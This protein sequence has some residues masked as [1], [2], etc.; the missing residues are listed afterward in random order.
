MK[1]E[2]IPIWEAFYGVAKHGNFSKASLALRIPVSQLSKR[3]SKLESQL[4]VRLF[5]RSTRAVSLTDEGKALLPRVSAVLEDLSSI[6]SQFEDQKSLSGTVRVTCIPF[7][8]ERLLIPV[9]EDFMRTN[10]DIHVELDLSETILNLI[11]SHIDLAIRIDEPD[12]SELVYRKLAPNDLVFCA[13]PK[14]LE[15]SKA[16]LTKPEHLHK[17]PIL[18]LAVHEKCSF[19]TGGGKLK[20]FSGSKKLTCENGAF[21]TDLAIHG[22]GVLVRTAWDVQQHLE[23]GR[24]IQVLKKYPLETFGHIYAV[25]PS[26]RFLAPRVHAFLDFVVQRSTHW[27]ANNI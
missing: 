8:A 3:V 16:P 25:I 5:Q 18:M 19:K 21:L 7:V 22:F 20:N 6:E 4:G 2:E 24:L 10:P 1:I 17:H 15:N 23:K 27:K 14:Y 11:D 9:L 26:R 13:S 12:D